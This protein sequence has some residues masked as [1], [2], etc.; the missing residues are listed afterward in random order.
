MIL[1]ENGFVDGLYYENYQSVRGL[2]Y[3]E[4][5]YYYLSTHQSTPIAG[6]T[7]Y[8]NNTNGLTLPDGTPIP[9]GIY[10]FGRDGKMKLIIKSGL[11]K[12]VY[13]ENNLPKNYAGLIYQNGNYY[14]INDNAKPVAGKCYYI[15]NTNGLT[16]PNG[17]AVEPGYYRFGEDGKMILVRNGL[18]DGLYYENYQSVRGL[19]YWEGDYYY[20]ST[21]Q[22]TPIAGKTYCITNTNGLLPK[23]WYEFNENGVLIL[24]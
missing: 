22:P 3:W 7:Y 14:Y 8:I 5:N 4:G 23:G 16:F 24:N 19:V 1:V 15:T 12:G 10:E 18:V 13:Y 2:V 21:Y 20:L 11:I 6:E 9:K 17:E